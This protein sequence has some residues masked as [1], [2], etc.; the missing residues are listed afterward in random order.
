MAPSR[1]RLLWLALFL[2]SFFVL[3]TQALDHSNI[4]Q[5]TEQNIARRKAL[6]AEPRADTAAS[7]QAAVDK[8]ASISPERVSNARAIVAKAIKEVTASNKV[9]WENPQRNVWSANPA[10]TSHARR[11]AGPD[12]YNIT[13]DVAAAAALVAEIDAAAEYK[14]GTLY[15]DYSRFHKLSKRQQPLEERAGSY[16][17][18]NLD[19]LGTQPFGN[20]ASYKVFRNVKDYGAKGDGVTVCRI[21]LISFWLFS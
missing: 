4:R 7:A 15:K 3:F 9:R 2:L 6:Q 8:L 14:N 5:V 18:A 19:N 1:A 20:D 10:S 12:Y 21:F 13:S 11:D 17:M 16:W